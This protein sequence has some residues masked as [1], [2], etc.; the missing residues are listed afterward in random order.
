[1]RML[2][3]PRSGCVTLGKS[4]NLSEPV[5]SCPVEM[6]VATPPEHRDGEDVARLSEASACLLA[7]CAL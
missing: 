7:Q 3:L 5:S 4:L 2:A 6:M 1:M